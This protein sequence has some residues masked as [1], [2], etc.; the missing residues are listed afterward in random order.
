MEATIETVDHESHA[1]ATK[2]PDEAWVKEIVLDNGIKWRANVETT[3]GVTKMLSLI[4]ENQASTAEGYRK[5]GDGLNEVKNTVVKE[6]TMEGASHDNLHVWLHPLIE[7]I[8]RL[9]KTESAEEGAKLTSNI[10][11]HL[12]G[13]FDYFN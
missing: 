8:K 13:Y 10:K 4:S 1:G 7:K 6:C 12:E 11:N 9:Q 3:N 2:G 5:L